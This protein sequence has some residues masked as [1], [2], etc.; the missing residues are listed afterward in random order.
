M[1]NKGNAI[2]RFAK[3][4]GE[5]ISIAAG[6]SEF[7]I[8]ML[9]RAD[10]RIMMP[11]LESEDIVDYATRPSVLIQLKQKIDDMKDH[12]LNVRVGGNDFSNAFGV[13][14]HIDETIY[15]ILPV[16]Q[17]LCD[18]LAARAWGTFSLLVFL[19]DIVTISFLWVL[20]FRLFGYRK[21]S[22]GE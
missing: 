21:H 15:D 16:S 9:A 1:L 5:A 8:P 20:G 12:V 13:R 22:L 7:D 4:F 3:K 17:L 19:L 6:D 11:I 10:T 18:I 14:R 2:E